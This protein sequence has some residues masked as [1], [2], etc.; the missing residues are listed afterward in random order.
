MSLVGWSGAYP[1]FRR[2]MRGSYPL[3]RCAISAAL[4]LS[5]CPRP[6]AVPTV[7]CCQPEETAPPRDTRPIAQQLSEECGYVLGDPVPDGSTGLAECI[8]LTHG[9][10][11]V[12]GARLITTV[13]GGDMF[14]IRAVFDFDC[15]P[16]HR[17]MSGYYTGVKEENGEGS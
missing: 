9:R 17:F 2:T 5:G 12:E 8:A 11:P 4:W 7:P 15:D 13:D 14:L 3:R 1:P 16:D 10:L 6:A